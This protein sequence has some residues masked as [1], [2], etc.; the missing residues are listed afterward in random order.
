[1]SWNGALMRAPQPGQRRWMNELMG[2][3][4]GQVRHRMP[5]GGEVLHG[6]VSLGC[7]ASPRNDDI[8]RKHNVVGRIRLRT[9]TNQ[10]PGANSP[11]V[12]ISGAVD[13]GQGH[14]RARPLRNREWKAVHRGAFS[15]FRGVVS[16]GP[17]VNAKPGRKQVG[18]RT[19]PALGSSPVLR[20]SRPGTTLALSP[21]FDPK[22]LL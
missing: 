7:W 13:A 17:Q 10:R 15:A 14:Y 5:A 2:I 21:G 18:S 12:I 20:R 9:K 16:N 11:G 8:G 19:A 3:L 6:R 1:M 22:S 4:R